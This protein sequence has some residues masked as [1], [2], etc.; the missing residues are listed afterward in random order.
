MSV[1]GQEVLSLRRLLL[2]FEQ[3]WVSGLATTTWALPTLL[4]SRFVPDTSALLLVPKPTAGT[5]NPSRLATG[6]I[7]D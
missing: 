7:R 4:A 6:S 3:P 1:D 5:F 2:S